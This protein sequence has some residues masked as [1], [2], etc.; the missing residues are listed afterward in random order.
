MTSRT[1]DSLS[2]GTSGSIARRT[3]P[4]GW[5]ATAST[6]APT[7]SSSGGSA[8]TTNTP[9]GNSHSRRGRLWRG[10]CPV[11]Q[12]NAPVWPSRPSALTRATSRMTPVISSSSFSSGTRA[13]SRAT[14]DRKAAREIP[15]NRLGCIAA[16]WGRSPS[17]S[18]RHPAIR[19]VSDAPVVAGSEVAGRRLVV[20]VGVVPAVVVA[21]GAAEAAGDGTPVGGVSGGGTGPPPPLHAPSTAAASAET[22]SRNGFG[23]M[24]CATDTTTNP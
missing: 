8:S 6:R 1:V 11:P 22:R 7:R 15:W 9:S 21:G 12:T 18:S 2:R 24:G 3:S 23:R 10:T 5:P 16:I 20:T 4:M 19:D 14:P 17:R 13:S